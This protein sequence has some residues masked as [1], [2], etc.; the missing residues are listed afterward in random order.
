[1]SKDWSMHPKTTI[2]IYFL[3]VVFLSTCASAGHAANPKK[4]SDTPEKAAVVNGVVLKKAEVDFEMELIKQ[5]PGYQISMTEQEYKETENE[6]IESMIT[7]ELLFQDGKKQSVTVAPSAIDEAMGEIKSGLENAAQLDSILKKVNLDKSGLRAKITRTLIAEKF[8]VEKIFRNVTVSDEECKAFYSANQSYFAVPEVAR[9][10]HI[11][12]KLRPNANEKEREKARTQLLSIKKELENGANFSTLAKKYSDCYTKDSGGDLDYFERGHLEKEFE[13]AA[14][15]LKV[16]EISDIVE[17]KKGLHLIKLT[18]KQE[19][20]IAPF[21]NVKD[22][23]KML[24]K[25]QKAYMA[26]LAHIEDLRKKADI[27]R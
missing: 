14:L 12:K 27:K 20:G 24:L 17:T 25:E 21:E 18:E 5:R 3:L 6:I 7:D 13:D 23:I 2:Q 15:K 26:K 9:A 22:S 11:L 16:G 1:M 19:Q 10:S 4:N 8:F